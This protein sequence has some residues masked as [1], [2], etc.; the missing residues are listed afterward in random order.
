MR[1]VLAMA[2]LTTACTAPAVL[3]VEVVSE[4]S[5]LDAIEVQ[6]QDREG[7]QRTTCRFER[8]GS[9]N[10]GCGFLEGD[11]LWQGGDQLTFL[12]YGASN[13]AAVNS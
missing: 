6:I 10:P 3:R 4:R 1:A 7:G 12:L 9:V 2:L 8:T 11:T 13:S 5:D